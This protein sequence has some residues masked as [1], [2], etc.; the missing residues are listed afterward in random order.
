MG[1]KILVI[2]SVIILIVVTV[3]GIGG[4]KEQKRQEQEASLKAQV[5]REQRDSIRLWTSMMPKDI[6]EC[7]KQAYHNKDGDILAT[8]YFKVISKDVEY[9][10][11]KIE[12]QIADYAKSLSRRV[13]SDKLMEAIAVYDRREAEYLKI[14]S[15]KEY[16][17]R[18]KELEGWVNG[19]AVAENQR[20]R[21]AAQKEAEL[22]K[23]YGKEDAEYIKNR[24]L[25]IG[26]KKELCEASWGIPD[27]NSSQTTYTGAGETVTDFWHYDNINNV[28]FVLLF[29]D[30]VL[31][32][33]TKFEDK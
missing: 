31:T 4:Y 14:T 33:V 1:K 8:Q 17:E 21:E 26:W 6:L 2:L 15:S 10:D 30:G 16:K 32:S 29:I 22:V 23:K 3:L 27:K 19:L 18:M 28:S 25:K 11:R 12:Q 5:E 13:D 20:N 24:K 7:A 9:E